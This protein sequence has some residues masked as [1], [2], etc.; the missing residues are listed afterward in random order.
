MAPATLGI[1]ADVTVLVS[2]EGILF[3]V[4]DGRRLFGMA[5]RGQEVR[6]PMPED[7]AGA[8]ASSRCRAGMH[9]DPVGPPG[10]PWRAA[11]IRRG[12]RWL[13]PCLVC[14]SKGYHPYTPQHSSLPCNHP[15][16]ALR[17]PTPVPCRGKSTALGSPRKV[18]AHPPGKATNL[19]PRGWSSYRKAVWR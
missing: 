18:V 17:T 8:D 16:V 2:E 15:R 4:G 1:A 12:P 19:N 13:R 14:D 10:S 11:T 7:G 9:S 3:Y 5:E 6:D